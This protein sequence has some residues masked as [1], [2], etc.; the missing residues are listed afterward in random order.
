MTIANVYPYLLTILLGE[1]KELLL[2]DIRSTQEYDAGHIKNACS[3]SVNKKEDVLKLEK[4]ITSNSELV[5]YCNSGLK[6]MY[7]SKL[8]SKDGIISHVLVGGFD[9][10]V[11]SMKEVKGL[12]TRENRVYL[13]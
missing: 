2:I 4:H 11:S 5:I 7:V 8:L 6:S 3:V 10:F 13:D 12:I 9:N 1:Q